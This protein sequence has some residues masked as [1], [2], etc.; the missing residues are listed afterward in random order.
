MKSYKQTAFGPTHFVDHGGAGPTTVLV[1]GL[2]GSTTNWNAVAPRLAN[3]SHVVAMDLPG[4]GLTPPGRDFKLTTHQAALE[5]FIET[6]E[7]PVTL[8]GNSTGGLISEMVAATRPELV[9]RLILISPATPWVFPD[10]RLDWPTVYRLLIQATPI[11]GA[12]Y[13]RYMLRRYTPEELVRL[14][15]QSVAYKAGR[16]PLEIVED[17]IDLHRVRRHLPWA[18]RATNR[19]ATSVA[20]L[21]ARKGE[22]ARMVRQIE[23][24]TLVLQGLE[25]HIISPTAVEWLCSLRPEWMLIQ[26]DDT[27]HTPQLDAPLR[28]VGIIEEWLAAS[29]PVSLGA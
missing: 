21:Y 10:D 26:M 7:T 8:I 20:L 9:S 25:D 27:G 13:G 16:V 23:A 2:G 18:T 14:G 12:A 1:H 5:A 29:D 6:L 28:T 24:P 3:R 15:F 17:T 19:T 11:I 4:F 22:F